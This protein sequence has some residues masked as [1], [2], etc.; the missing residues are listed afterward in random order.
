M[1]SSSL[2]HLSRAWRRQHALPGCGAA[3][4][5]TSCAVSARMQSVASRQEA[6]PRA[7]EGCTACGE[8]KGPRALLNS[9]SIIGALTECRAAAAAASVQPAANE[10]ADRRGPRLPWG[11]ARLRHIL[12]EY[13]RLHELHRAVGNSGH[14]RCRRRRR[15]THDAVDLGAGAS[16]QPLPAQQPALWRVQHSSQPCAPAGGGHRGQRAGPGGSAASGAAVG[17]RAKRSR[18]LLPGG[19]WRER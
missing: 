13:S 17:P 3:G 9:P 14:C 12:E 1:R 15:H 11:P 18:Q 5:T 4:F 19:G 7:P 6:L 10:A 8:S 16:R 2:R